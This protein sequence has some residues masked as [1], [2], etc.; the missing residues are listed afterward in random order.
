MVVYVWV[1]A[2]RFFSESEVNS[3]RVEEGSVRMNLVQPFRR[4]E[5]AIPRPTAVI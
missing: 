3:R 5:R 4:R 1:L 2:V